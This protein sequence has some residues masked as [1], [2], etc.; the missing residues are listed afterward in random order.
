MHLS[1][2]SETEQFFHNRSNM[3]DQE[4]GFVNGDWMDDMYSYPRPVVGESS[5]NETCKSQPSPYNKI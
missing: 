3:W 1:F 4:R 2:L 5:I